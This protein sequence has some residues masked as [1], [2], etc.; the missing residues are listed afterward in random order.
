MSQIGISSE[1]SVASISPSTLTVEGLF[2]GETD[3][4]YLPRQAEKLV[5]TKTPWSQSRPISLMGD[6][7]SQFPTNLMESSPSLLLP[8]VEP[9]EVQDSLAGH[10]KQG[11]QNL[12]DFRRALPPCPR[13]SLSQHRAQKNSSRV[14]KKSNELVKSQNRIW[15]RRV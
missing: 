4:L 14:T 15:I 11:Q 7:I 13:R 2:G 12:E 5:A 8:S 1:H 3:E 9:S 10:E 6:S